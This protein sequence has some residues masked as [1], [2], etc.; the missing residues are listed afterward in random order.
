M[1]PVDVRN[2]AWD[3]VKA[4]CTGDR[5]RVYAALLDGGPAT[6]R[7][8]AR[9]LDEPLERIR[10]RVTELFQIGYVELAGKSGREGVYAAV[11]EMLVQSRFEVE[12]R[13]AFCV[14]RQEFMRL[15]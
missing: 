9:H 6:T 13:K 1:K 5:R 3:E 12:H 10:P 11:P 2:E 14:P 7:A 15:P 4:R 8:L